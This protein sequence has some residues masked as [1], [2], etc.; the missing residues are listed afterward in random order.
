MAGLLLDLRSALRQLR[1][2]PG[3]TATAV[4]LLG[5]G[6]CAN[7]TAFSWIDGTL[8]NPV[9]GAR[10]ASRLVTIMRGVWSNSPSPPFSYPDY[11]DLRNANHSLSGVLAYNH[12]WLTLTSGDTPQRIYVSNDS[13]NY[14][15]VLGI[16]PL[17][18]RFFFAGEEAQAGGTPEVVLSAALW[19]TRYHSDPVIVGKSIQ[20]ARHPVTVIGVAPPGFLGAMPGIRE[21]A[22]IP[23]DPLGGNDR[24]QDRGAAW[25]NVMG[26]LR[27]GISRQ[28]A[29]QE[30]QILMQR[31]VAEYPAD[32]PGVNTITLDPLW[33]SPFGANVYLAAFLPILLAIAGVV[34]LLTCAN[35][36]TLA[37]VRFVGRRREIGIRH[38]LGARSGALMRQMVLEGLFISL[39]G[40]LL[41]IALTAWT[42]RILSGIV[43]PSSNP[44]VL[45]GSVD[46]PVISAILLL[47]FA[48][49]LLCGALPA[50]RS[51]RIAP[52]EVLREEAA[53]HSAG[54][55]NRRLLSGLVAAQIALSLA[56]LVAAGLLLRTLHNTRAASPGFDASHVVTASVD[57]RTA[58]YSDS[59]V[60]AFQQKLLTAARSLPRAQSASLTDWLPFSY[61][62]KTADAW[63]EGYVPQ[64]HESGEVRHADVSAGYFAT[65]NIPI[66]EGRA[67]TDNDDGNAPFV[68]IVDETAAH[69]YWPGQNP[70]GRRLRIWGH[71]FTVVGVARNS[72]HQRI[73][74]SA[75]PMV[76]MSF[77]QVEDPETILQVRTL[78]DPGLLVPALENAVH[79]VNPRLIVFDVRPLSESIRI[80]GT[81][82]QIATAFAAVFAFLALILAASGIYGVVAYRTQL[83]THE[84]GIR[85]AL[86]ASRGDVLRLI[87][88]QG[89]RLTALG[90][91]AG[92]VLSLALTRYLSS[93]LY[94]VNATDPLTLIAVTALLALISALACY[95]PA[96]RATHVDPASAIRE[97]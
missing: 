85:M 9:P 47:T 73:G 44:I 89:L 60:I 54:T 39:G 38:A 16:R 50:W 69:H 68:L 66:L 91:A 78:H 31:L 81:F 2:S 74:E 46:A 5:L 40:G 1:R 87:V 51:S 17:L 67:F 71:W 8:L 59:Q 4:L 70:V 3:F 48:A 22:W 92:I 52:A 63:P 19:R 64:W 57:L 82:E 25:L 65:M 56:L 6:I 12:D 83:R 93:M 24:I 97:L 20:I 34:L 75:E 41:A 10:D 72:A 84:I 43:P 49:T 13:D 58:G 53:S 42:S 77:F 62:R 18:G 11:R 88:F 79:Q 96:L 37:L 29:T 26:R 23:L 55:S 94:G 21:D 15:S 35:V 32:H 80:S 14:F 7:S 95:L 86:G 27:P 36:A 30:L 28:R 45:G 33:R 90:L 76:Y 61:T